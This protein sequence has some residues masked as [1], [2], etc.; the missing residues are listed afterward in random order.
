MF[1]KALF[2]GAWKHVHICDPC[3]PAVGTD[4]GC[5]RGVRRHYH[6]CGVTDDASATLPA[7]GCHWGNS[8]SGHP[9]GHCTT[10][11]NAVLSV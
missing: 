9:W 4:G 7:G 3:G 1:T 11:H 6:T 8:S 2:M 5:G 10:C